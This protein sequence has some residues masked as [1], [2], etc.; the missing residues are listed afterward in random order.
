MEDQGMKNR[1][2]HVHMPSSHDA[3]VWF[4]REIHDSKFWI[5]LITAALV[6]FV[7]TLAYM[8]RAMG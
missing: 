6:L 3:G 1:A 2:R 4:G 5:L 8:T 7:I